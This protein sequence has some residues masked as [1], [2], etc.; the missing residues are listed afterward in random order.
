MSLVVIHNRDSLLRELQESALWVSEGLKL[1]SGGI[2]C[3]ELI[4]GRPKGKRER[5]GWNSRSEMKGE[6]EWNEAKSWV[7]GE[8]VSCTDVFL[9]PTGNALGF[10]PQ[11]WTPVPGGGSEKK[12]KS[13]RG[14]TLK[15]KG[16]TCIMTGWCKKKKKETESGHKSSGYPLLY[17]TECLPFKGLVHIRM[18]TNIFHW[19]QQKNNQ[20]YFLPLQVCYQYG[21]TGTWPGLWTNL[22]DQVHGLQRENFQNKWKTFIGKPSLALWKVFWSSHV[23]RG[24]LE[25]VQ[26]SPAPVICSSCHRERCGW[27][28]GTLVWKHTLLPTQFSLTSGSSLITVTFVPCW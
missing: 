22:W 13:V 16:H 3:S 25:L 27:L 6:D 18:I 7:F 1:A 21:S 20:L 11:P 28:A 15:R 5:A 23:P 2:T 14:V 8:H 24:D 19:S 26:C 12:V 10:R 9:A 17:K 4:G